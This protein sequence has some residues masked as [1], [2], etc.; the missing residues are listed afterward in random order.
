MER[1]S[2]KLIFVS[3]VGIIKIK[4]YEIWLYISKNSE[5]PFICSA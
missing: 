5:K 2:L 3:I 4:N 1:V